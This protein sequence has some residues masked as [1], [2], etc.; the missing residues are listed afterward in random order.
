[1]YSSCQTCA[2]ISRLSSLSRGLSLVLRKYFFKRSL[3]KALTEK[4]GLVSNR[5]E[6]KALPRAERI[7]RVRYCEHPPE[8]GIEIGSVRNPSLDE[9]GYIFIAHVKQCRYCRAHYL[10]A[11]LEFR[12]Y[13]ASMSAV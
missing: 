13:G 1:M 4:Q 7:R 10:D 11:R 2:L 6:W 5:Q 12:N 9:D 3:K 8:L